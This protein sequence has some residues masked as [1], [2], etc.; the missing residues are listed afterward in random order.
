MANSYRLHKAT[1]QAVVSIHGKDFYLG[2]YGSPESKERYQ[3]ILQSQSSFQ[4][5]AEQYLAY[6]EGYYR[7]GK[8]WL[9]IKRA[10]ELFHQAVETIPA[11]Q[12]SKSHLRKFQRFLVDQSVC[13]RYINQLVG[14]LLRGVKW[15]ASNDLLEPN[16]YHDLRLVPSLRAGR[17]PAP[18]YPDIGPAP[19]SS[20]ASVLRL[21]HPLQATLVQVQLLL[22][23]RPDEI[24]QMRLQDIDR[25]QQ[26]WVYRPTQHKN[27]YRGHQRLIYIGPEAQ[28]LLQ[29][30]L[31]SDFEFVFCPQ[32][33][34]IKQGKRIPGKRYLVTSY[35]RMLLRACRKAG[36]EPFTPHQLRHTAATKIASAEG[37]DA[38]RIIL[39]HKSINTTLIYAQS[40]LEL[41]RSA[42]RR[43][44]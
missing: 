35:S 15:L 1:G 19:M 43:L 8:E 14:C 17:S 40:N 23:C 25:S 39:G 13:R 21:L 38:A 9:R 41:A 42:I 32:K 30:W 10:F 6:A 5:L 4:R 20:I 7:G 29:P 31:T 2:K 3:K 12:I 27:K 26:P 16:R 33:I 34:R 24:L 37:W 28:R 36:V 18:D 22:G 44:G 11:G